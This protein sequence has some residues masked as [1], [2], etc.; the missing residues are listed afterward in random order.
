MYYKKENKK[1]QPVNFGT[2]ITYLAAATSHR[3]RLSAP[4]CRELKSSGPALLSVPHIR[5]WHVHTIPGYVAQLHG[6]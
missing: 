6:L 4:A 5:S 1:A 2:K 3:E